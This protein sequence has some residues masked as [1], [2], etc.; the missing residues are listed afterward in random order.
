LSAETQY[1][2]QSKCVF[3]DAIT[4]HLR[5]R[6]APDAREKQNRRMKIGEAIKQLRLERGATQED[7]ALEA[8]TNAGN[9]SR[10]ERCQQQPALEL[11]E[12]VAAALAMTVA[13]LYAYAEAQQPKVTKSKSTSKGNSEDNS[14]AALLFRRGF[15]QLTPE[16]KHL[17][18]EFVKLLNRTQSGK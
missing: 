7:V 8:G 15:N 6:F 12:K 3:A 18:V 16:N 14:N 11:V 5:I 1:L 13:D 17:A 9:L 2:T 10:I 4:N